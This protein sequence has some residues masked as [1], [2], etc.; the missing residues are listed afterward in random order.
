MFVLWAKHMYSAIGITGSW[1][2]STGNSRAAIA[3][4]ATNCCWLSSITRWTVCTQT[5]ECSNNVDIDTSKAWKIMVED[6][7]FRSWNLVDEDL[8]IRSWNLVSTLVLMT[9][10]NRQDE[11]KAVSK[12]MFEKASITNPVGILNA[13]RIL[14]WIL[15]NSSHALIERYR[16][17]VFSRW[18][19]FKQLRSKDAVVGSVQSRIYRPIQKSQRSIMR[20]EHWDDSKILPSSSVDW[21]RTRIQTSM[22]RTSVEIAYFELGD[23]QSEDRPVKMIEPHVDWFLANGNVQTCPVIS[24]LGE[25]S[26]WFAGARSCWLTGVTQFGGGV[27]PGGHRDF[28]KAAG[29]SD[30]EGDNVAVTK[31]GNVWKTRW[32]CEQ[33]LFLICSNMYVWGFR[34]WDIKLV[35]IFVSEF[36][37]IRPAAVLWRILVLWLFPCFR[38][39]YIP[40][41]SQIPTGTKSR[42]E[43][44][45]LQYPTLHPKKELQSRVRHTER[46]GGTHKSVRLCPFHADESRIYPGV[47]L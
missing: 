29:I 25:R 31:P 33:E 3:A 40:A 34:P 4:I 38:N 32:E 17:S 21:D 7:W 47:E 15:S 43:F 18:S 36:P 23:F 16:R 1:V 19:S 42:H 26:C 39:S 37:A 2:N 13:S 45:V 28:A 30:S 8:W 10:L 5:S 6:L 11:S 14:I 46:T 20:A 22:I 24:K 41:L 35:R 9:Q 12:K 27:L 44:K